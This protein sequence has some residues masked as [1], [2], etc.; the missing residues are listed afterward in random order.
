[1]RRDCISKVEYELLM[2]NPYCQHTCISYGLD[3]NMHIISLLS[4]V[5]SIEAN[6]TCTQKT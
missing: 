2:H 6:F 5:I 1:M 4:T 3:Y